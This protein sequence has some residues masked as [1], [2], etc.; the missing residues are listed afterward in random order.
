MKEGCSET[1]YSKNPSIEGFELLEEENLQPDIP[2]ATVETTKIYQEYMSRMQINEEESLED[3][4]NF[5][6]VDKDTGESYDSRNDKRVKQLFKN[7]D[8]I[9]LEDNFNRMK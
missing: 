5:L 4:Q 1:L 8:I 6:I 7:N 2:E 3:D 9:N